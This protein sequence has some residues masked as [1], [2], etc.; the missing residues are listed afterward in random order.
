MAETVEHNGSAE[1]GVVKAQC[2]IVDLGPRQSIVT[3]ICFLD[4]MVDQLTSHAQLGVFMQV[5]INGHQLPPRRDY[6]A[7]TQSDERPHDEAI[8]E[9]TGEALGAALH[10]LRGTRSLKTAKFFVPLDEALTE[11]IVEV[12]LCGE[13]ADLNFDLAPYGK[14]PRTGRQ[15][16]GRFRT[17]YTELFWR[18]L[19]NAFGCSVSLKKIRGENAH[20]I[21][22]A[23]FKAFSRALR[24]SLDSE[25]A[26]AKNHAAPSVH[27]TASR[28]R[29]T[30]ET[31]ISASVNLDVATNGGSSIDTGVPLLDK[32]LN[33]A[34]EQSGFDFTLQCKGDIHIDDHHS[35][36]D[37]S[38][39][40]GQCINEAL[41]DKTGCNRMGW[42]EGVSGKARV[43]VSLDLSNRPHF[44]CDLDLDEEFLGGEAM[45]NEV[46]HN[47]LQS[48]ALS[49][50]ML[51]HA[52]L[53]L[54][55]E[56][57]ATVHVLQLERGTQ[58][59]FTWDLAL[60]T[61]KALGRAL[62]F[63]SQH[64]PR[65]AGAVASSKGTLSV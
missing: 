37:V 55:V 31:S 30:K 41:G 38:I 9:A 22:E 17:E 45:C 42:A 33:E 36:E 24:R 1:R 5:H 23:T 10:S 61:A 32:L 13:K 64:D 56:M 15:W 63:C 27:R 51:L 34:R 16:I 3:G 43:V 52:L 20:H 29:T 18:S 49:C 47:G 4:H 35:T 50:E 62:G 46:T 14:M 39:A 58:P 40:L 6:A 19:M 21:V 57:R 12:P 28:S 2:K 54:S 25:E 65:R 44:E 48:A 53:S 11:A 60:A 26:A 7:E 59:G 8:F